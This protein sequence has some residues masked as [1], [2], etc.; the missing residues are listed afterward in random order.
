MSFIMFLPCVT[1][2]LAC[3]VFFAG[4]RC[5]TSQ[6]KKKTAAKETMA[7]LMSTNSEIST[8]DIVCKM[9]SGTFF[10]NLPGGTLISN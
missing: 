7:Y 6:E 5:V 10:R 3:L 1:S 4:E 2:D 9:K 8:T